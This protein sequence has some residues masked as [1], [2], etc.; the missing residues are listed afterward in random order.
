[1]S[2]AFAHEAT[3]AAIVA[4]FTGAV[5]ILA[6][7]LRRREV[8]SPEQSRKFLHVGGCLAAMA[9]PALFSTHWTALAVCASFTA[10]VF[11]L[12]R[13]G[14]LH[15][16][17]DV[18]RSSYGEVLHPIALYLCYLLADWRNSFDFYEIAVLVLALS[19]TAAALVG[20]RYGRMRYRVSDSDCR[21][22]EGSFVFF[23]V[24]YAL[25]HHILLL[26]VGM[27]A[28]EASLLSL[29]IA[30]LATLFEAVSLGGAD[31][32]AV[33]VCV[34]TILLKNATPDIGAMSRQFAILAVSFASTSIPLRLLGEMDGSGRVVTSLLVYLAAGLYSPWWGV[35]TILAVL[36]MHAGRTL[37]L[38]DVK[39][40]FAFA[41]LPFLTIMGF[42][43]TEKLGH[44]RPFATA[45]LAYLAS[46]LISSLIVRH[47]AK[48]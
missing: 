37:R 22:V 13:R 14:D 27:P 30:V 1:M 38:G 40:V 18:R 42:N 46:L 10:L 20:E 25:T 2:T 4:V 31:N 15:A 19:D 33:P 9:F 21:S 3:G 6:E 35:A 5:F 29:L 24:T 36:A 28:P 8:L 48:R 41:A 11:A 12:G 26:R 17:N 45:T 39:T 23:L 43:L 47:H 34:L 44:L 7:T 16:V 32:L